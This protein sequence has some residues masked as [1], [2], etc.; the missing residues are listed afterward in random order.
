VLDFS[1]YLSTIYKYCNV[2]IV[3]ISTKRALKIYGLQ[4]I[5]NKRGVSD[6]KDK[7]L[8]EVDNLESE[9]IDFLRNLIKIPTENPPGLNYPEMAKFLD[10]KLSSLG[11]DVELV[12]VPPER[13]PELVPF[14]DPKY[15]RVNVLARLPG[16]EGKPTLHFNGHVDVV[17]AGSGW[18][19]PPYEGV[20]KDGKI[21]GRG[22]CDMKS[23]LAAMVYAIEAIRR[24]G[25]KLK[26]T[27][28]FSFVVDEETAGVKNAGT[29]YII[30]QGYVSKDSVDYVIVTEPMD[31]DKICIG[32]RGAIWWKINVYGKQAHGGAPQLGINAAYKSANLIHL[33]EH[34][35]LPRLRERVS[36]YNIY[37][38]S[39][40]M[41]SISLGVINC[42]VK[43]NVV[44]EKCTL[45]VDRRFIPEE[46]AEEVRREFIELLEALRKVDPQFKYDIEETYFSDVILVSENQPLVKI[47]EESVKEVLGI[48]PQKILDAATDDNRFFIKNAGIESTVI[49]GPGRAAIPHTVDEYIEIKDLLNGTKVL[50]LTAAK[51]L[52]LTT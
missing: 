17:P 51:L 12:E 40:K 48:I 33:M 45:E 21:Y 31:V 49:Y 11:Y 20:V 29:Y 10:E 7:I 46:T 30:E 24:A 6:L 15:R 16:S 42:G 41:S 27:V 43:V 50:A 34:F 5:I 36:K 1:T 3:R 39:G 32:N 35:L 52:G 19:V 37:P 23:G 2:R 44:P 4:D 18:S 38:E 28:E 26:G 8:R 22:A 25:F 9:I 47:L 14:A 13:F